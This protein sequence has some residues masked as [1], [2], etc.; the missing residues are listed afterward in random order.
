MKD[1]TFTVAFIA[2]DGT[3]EYFEKTLKNNIE[4]LCSNTTE[5]YDLVMFLDGL[6]RIEYGR[7][8]EL[9]K[10]CGIG[11]VRLRNRTINCA[12]GDGANNP[13][14]HLISEETKYLVTIEAD[15]AV[16]KTKDCDILRS[17]RELF[18]INPN[19]CVATRID[20]YD[21]WQEKMCFLEHNIGQGLRSVNRVS[22]HFLVYDTKR[23]CQ[24]VSSVG[25]WPLSGMYD[26]GNTWY[27]YE[28]RV[29]KTFRFPD[30]P[31]IGFID[32]IPFKVYHCDEKIEVGS[33][34]Y[35]RDLETR[36]NM[37]YRRKHEC[38]ALY[39]DYIYTKNRDE[40][41]G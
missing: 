32:S 5:S 22:S 23:C 28:D 2:S 9:A 37:F 4:V 18:E 35:K 8:I 40:N 3:Y 11:E 27:N 17:I 7:Y 30:G 25:G 34:F 14:M 21:C 24:F 12:S 38:D 26:T 16:F 6:E 31:G 15:I 39:H 20:D 19:L 1:Y 10:E 33:P 36:L 13:H 41:N 29:G